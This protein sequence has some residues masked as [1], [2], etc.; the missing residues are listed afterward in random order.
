MSKLRHRL[1]IVALCLCPLIWILGC[2]AL[3]HCPGFY[4]TAA[5]VSLVPTLLS[6]T[7]LHRLLGLALLIVSI[8]LAFGEYQAE[9]RQ[10]ANV[11]RARALA[12]TRIATTAPENSD[13]EPQHD[14]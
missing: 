4:I 13:K 6:T 9:S 14:R 3:C 11:A 12:A 8:G 7:R 10:Q 1:S 5:A 2:T